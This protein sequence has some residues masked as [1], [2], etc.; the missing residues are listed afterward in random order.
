MNPTANFQPQSHAYAASDTSIDADVV[1]ILNLKIAARTN[2][3]FQSIRPRKTNG[4]A[5]FRRSGKRGSCL[6]GPQSVGS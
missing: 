6:T 5:S 2:L 3:N 1:K 4:A